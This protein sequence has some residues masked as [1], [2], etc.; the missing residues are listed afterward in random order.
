MWWDRINLRSWNTLKIQVQLLQSIKHIY[1][2]MFYN[3][4]ME[5]HIHALMHAHVNKQLIGKKK[6]CLFSF[7]QSK[8]SEHQLC[9]PNWEY[10]SIHDGAY[11]PGASWPITSIIL[12]SLLLY[13]LW[14]RP[15]AKTRFNRKSWPTSRNQISDEVSVRKKH[16]G[17][18]RWEMEEFCK[19]R[20]EPECRLWGRKIFSE[21]KASQCDWDTG[22]KE[23]WC[24]VEADFYKV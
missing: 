4:T 5:L 6:S 22:N 23:G 10:S 15:G 20:E 18:A 9:V 2:M 8:F 17:L 19:Q 24:Q 11:N 12:T 7:I 1:E 16:L 3:K 13:V 14:N 21:Q